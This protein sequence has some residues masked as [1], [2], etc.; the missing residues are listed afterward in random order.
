MGRLSRRAM[1]S[2]LSNRLVATDNKFRDDQL[3]FLVNQIK[4]P[5]ESKKTSLMNKDASERRDRPTDRPTH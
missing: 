3:L 5:L 2:L 1:Y 4:K